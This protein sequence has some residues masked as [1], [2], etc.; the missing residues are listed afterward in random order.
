MVNK[1]DA[2]DPIELKGLRWPSRQSVVVSARTGAGMRRPARRDRA[3]AAAAEREV[4][5]GPIWIPKKG[6]TVNL[7][8][9][10]IALYERIIDL[11][12]ENEFVKR[13]GKFSYQRS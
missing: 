1:A 7:T 2:A 9:A 5:F 10:N 3:A 11:Y 6:T 4:N 13:D 8:P 12:E